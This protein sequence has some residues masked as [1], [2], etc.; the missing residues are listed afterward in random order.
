MAN[1]CLYGLCHAAVLSLGY[2]PAIGFI[3]TGKQLSFVYDVA[4]LYKTEVSIPI[5]FYAAKL[6]TRD[7]GRSTRLLCRDAFR[8]SRLLRRVVP[9]IRE[10]LGDPSDADA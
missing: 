1:S 10:A 4:D 8:R 5:A 3:H 6:G 7:L 2:S 9:D